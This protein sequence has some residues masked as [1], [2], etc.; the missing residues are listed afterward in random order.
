MSIYLPQEQ[1]QVSVASYGM[2]VSRSSSPVLGSQILAPPAGMYH[3]LPLPLVGRTRS[4]T[5]GDAKL[6]P[7][8]AFEHTFGNLENFRN[9]QNTFGSLKNF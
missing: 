9:F 5:V 3:V 7:F 2:D 1:Y 6:K 4:N 8:E